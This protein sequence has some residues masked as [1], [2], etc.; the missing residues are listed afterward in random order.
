MGSHTD[1]GKRYPS[2]P[3]RPSRGTL[4]RSV[5][6]PIHLTANFKNERTSSS[7]PLVQHVSNVMAHAQKPDL[8]FSTKRTSPFKSAGGGVSSVDCWQP[9]VCESAVVMLDTPCSDVECKTT[10]YPL[11]SHVPPSLPLPCVTV[12]H[13]VS[14]EL[15]FS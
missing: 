13:Q 14:T 12:C 9:E 6:L 10:G 5:K 7:I 4:T 2:S 1:R 8:V 11:Q 15:Y 3:E